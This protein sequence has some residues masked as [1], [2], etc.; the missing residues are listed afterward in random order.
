MH[1]R[2]VLGRSITLRVA[3]CTAACRS[4]PSPQGLAEVGQSAGLFHYPG[5]Q[6]M[7][8]SGPSRVARRPA[9][10]RTYADLSHSSRTEGTTTE[11]VGARSEC[12]GRRAVSGGRWPKRDDLP[13]AHG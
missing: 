4:F 8:I 6:F 10:L 5:H 2:T 9:T 7:F 12:I 11:A 1:S 13:F 3:C